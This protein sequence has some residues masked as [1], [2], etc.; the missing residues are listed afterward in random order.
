MNVSGVVGSS[1]GSLPI[2]SSSV[3]QPL[4]ENGSPTT[5]KSDQNGHNGTHEGD[6]DARFEKVPWCRLMY[7]AVAW[8]VILVPAVLKDSVLGCGT[9]DYWLVALIPFPLLALITYAYGRTLVAEHK[10]RP[11]ESYAKGDI[12]WTD[13]EIVRYPLLC[14]VAGVAAALLGVGGG[15]VTNPLMLELGVIPEVSR[16]TS[17]F[18]ILFTSSCTSMQYLL[19]GKIDGDHAVWYLGFG[20]IG[21][22]IGHYCV[23]WL[24]HR[25]HSTSVLVFILAVGVSASAIAM[26]ATDI[27]DVAMNGFTGGGSVC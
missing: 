3:T 24:L 15:M 8:L 14:S 10:E 9:W 20:F 23:E 18:M 13:R 27:V 21:A 4:I 6:L 1:S 11:K 2:T 25:Y 19:L 16:V 12:H 7:L 26:A 5:P 17:A 22:I